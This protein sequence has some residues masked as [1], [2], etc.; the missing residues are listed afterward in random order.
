[1]VPWKE[2]KKWAV[3]I[4]LEK[5]KLEMWQWHERWVLKRKSILKKWQRKVDTFKRLNS[6]RI[7]TP[8]NSIVPRHIC[9]NKML[10][11]TTQNQ[12]QYLSSFHQHLPLLSS[13]NSGASPPPLFGVPVCKTKRWQKSV[14]FNHPNL[15]FTWN[16]IW[17]SYW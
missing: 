3:T 8:S 13:A 12:F 2:E 9:A 16:L 15:F 6:I 11:T 17:P 14:F 4:I 1:M 7:F 10:Q 5:K